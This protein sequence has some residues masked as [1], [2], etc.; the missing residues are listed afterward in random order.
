MSSRHPGERLSF[1]NA[2]CT[3]RYAGPLPDQKGDW[4]GV[5]WDDPERG[6][7]DGLYK[8]T[9]LFHTLSSSPNCAS[10]TRA[11]RVP[12]EP[13]S[14]LQALRYKYAED[15]LDYAPVGANGSIEISGKVVEEVGFERIRQQQALLHH[16][17]IVILDGLRVRGVGLGADVERAQEEI[18]SICPNITELDLSRNLF[19][20]YKDVAEICAPLKEL[21][22]LKIS[23]LRLLDFDLDGSSAFPKVEE[24]HLDDSLLSPEQILRMLTRRN[25]DG[26]ID[27]LFPSL[28][29]LSVA[30]NNLSTFFA[31]TPPSVSIVLT[32]VKTLVMDMNTFTSLVPLCISLIPLFPT[33]TTLSLQH[34]K[35]STFN[36]STSTTDQPTPLYPSITTLNLSHNAITDSRVVSSLPE[37]FPNLTSLQV[38]DNPFFSNLTSRT[39]HGIEDAAFLITVARLPTLTMLNYT[40][41]TEKDRM[42]G[43]LY[44]LSVAE[45]E[46]QKALQNTQSTTNNDFRRSLQD[47]A[48]YIE[49]CDKYDRV[50]IVG[51]SIAAQSA[52]SP[53]DTVPADAVS[54]ASYRP[55]KYPPNTLGAQ[56]VTL[57]F[58][59][60][61]PSKNEPPT[62]TDTI[63]HSPTPE[64]VT[65][66]LPRTLDVYR[67]KSLLLRKIG[68]EWNLKPLEFTFEIVQDAGEQV[69]EIPDST[70][71]IGD[72]I[73]ESVGDVVLKVR[74]RPA[75]SVM[76][77]AIGSMALERL[78][79]VVAV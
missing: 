48:R 55:P 49:L 24:L 21:R 54:A 61:T 66:T 69:E 42:D 10:F 19:E 14:F 77:D 25:K 47:W 32:T 7:H 33:L 72:W 1:S 20:R 26:S 5:E 17:K 30:G 44:Y 40:S 34:N 6:K 46:I 13:R 15:D 67:V 45:K 3:I 56:L 39:T 18:T 28:K 57:T 23:G 62:T 2:L 75:V 35:I 58:R 79:G 16:L 27:L 37:L 11:T 31:P 12:D 22:V 60:Q 73:P 50:H 71:R 8:G 70:R 76:E 29:S 78:K 52:H 74:P 38:S 41:I 65:L 51:R 68:R 9:R 53:K 59:L 4:L 63:P 43:E 64:S 36:S